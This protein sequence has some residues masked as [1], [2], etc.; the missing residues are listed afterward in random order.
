MITGSYPPNDI[1]GVGDY[2]ACFM[3]MTESNEWSLY[4]SNKW[5][6]NELINKIKVINS[7]KSKYIIMQYPTQ[8]Y[9]WSILPQLL[10]IYY[11]FF[12]RKKFI[13]VL[14]EFSQR[15]FKAKLATIP[16]LFSNRIIFT[17]KFEKDFANK[18]LP[19]RK[20]MYHIVKIF[21]NISSPSVINKYSNRDYDI[22]YFGHIRP[23][24]GLEDFVEVISNLNE[25]KILIVGQV[26]N[27]YKDY[28]KDIENKCMNNN[29]TIFYNKS[30]EEVSELLNNSKIVFLPFP[31]GVSERRGTL[32]ASLSNGAA[33]FTYSGKYV[34]E[35]LLNTCFI[36]KIED[37]QNDIL[38]FLETMNDE[39]YDNV[40]KKNKKYLETEIPHSWED[41]VRMYENI[42]NSI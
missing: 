36:T 7:Y 9:G 5:G 25:K 30:I 13:T 20:E 37:A 26:L 4:Y 22:C 41:I 8:G 28:A 29:V 16:F 14:H 35:G 39:E 23:L 12:T 11:S 10:A 34:T 6:L 33:V 15:T 21:S 32:L 38:R 42:I 19:C 40:Q 17:N 1:C 3:S 24:K 2:T 31:D 18:I 27:E